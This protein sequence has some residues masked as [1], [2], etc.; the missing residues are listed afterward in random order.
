MKK[1]PLLNRSHKV[2]AH[3]LVD[4]DVYELVGRK[5][6]R[7]DTKGYAVSSLGWVNGKKMEDKLHRLVMGLSPGDG[8]VVDHMN[9]DRLDNRRQNLRVVTNALNKQNGR[10][11]RDSTSQHVGVSWET[12]KRRWVAQVGI[13]GRH[14]H[15]GRFRDELQAAKA[16]DAYCSEHQPGH[17]RIFN[18]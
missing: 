9:H 8:L 10:A 16:Y 13:D 11:H 12:S 14:V 17:I 18:D 5:K 6:W 2:V 3:T 4:D 7:R 1:I 15:I